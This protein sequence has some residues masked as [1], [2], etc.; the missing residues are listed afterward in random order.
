MNRRRFFGVA[1][2]AAAASAIKLPSS[3]ASLPETLSL[4]FSSFNVE[5][6]IEAAQ[7]VAGQCD[8]LGLDGAT[9]YDTKLMLS[10]SLEAPHGCKKQ[11]M[12]R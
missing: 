1:L 9:L 8:S 6:L 11:K 5:Q 3:P 7:T 2:T 10:P 4:P 12:K